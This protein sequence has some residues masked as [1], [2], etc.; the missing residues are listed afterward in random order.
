MLSETISEVIGDKA[1]ERIRPDLNIEKWSIWQPAKSKNA[2]TVRIFEREVNLDGG[3]TLT[4]QVE[5]G[6]TQRG[7]F[8][9]EDQKT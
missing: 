5:I 7:T 3:S 6:F 4:A 2:P 1:L 9:T 8:T